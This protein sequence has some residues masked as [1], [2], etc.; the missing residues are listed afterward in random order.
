MRGASGSVVATTASSTRARCV[1]EGTACRM[2]M[3]WVV[4]ALLIVLGAVY[5]GRRDGALARTE[6]S[7]EDSLSGPLNASRYPVG[8][9]LLLIGAATF[10][11]PFLPAFQDVA[12][13]PLRLILLYAAGL[14]L[15]A[16]GGIFVFKA[17]IP[18]VAILG[19]PIPLGLLPIV[20]G[21][22]L[23][24]LP[25]TTY[26]GGPFAPITVTFTSPGE[27]K[28]LP[29]GQSF[30]VSGR[31]DGLPADTELWLL[32]ATAADRARYLYF[33]S[34]APLDL[35]GG[36]FFHDLELFAD[37]AAG[38]KVFLAVYADEECSGDLRESASDR[39]IVEQGLPYLPESCEVAGS[40]EFE[41]IR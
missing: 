8:I 31:V 37:S 30:E 40:S 21:V 11:F 6:S 33:S 12:P 17:R 38:R 28:R 29:A 14:V 16:L 27:G 10:A 23:F 34:Y 20:T 4:G 19:V 2:L 3:L 18:W 1:H 32:V 22:C 9:G 24:A 26:Y 15:V 5:V 35:G 39:V 36:V 13:D 41:I 7:E 25:F